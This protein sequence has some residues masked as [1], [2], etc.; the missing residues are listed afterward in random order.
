MTSL[1]PLHGTE[2]INCA[3]ANAKEEI[4]VV[5]ELCGYGK[6]ITTF[7][8]ELKKACD[9]I[10]LEIESFKDLSQ[11]QLHRNTIEIAPQTPNQF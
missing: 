9:S 8:Q 2:L 6:D 4:E 5:S 10:G 3:Q 7:E 1:K 11:E